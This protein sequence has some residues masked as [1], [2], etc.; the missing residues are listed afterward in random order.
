MFDLSRILPGARPARRDERGASATEY[1]LLI[2][3]IAA[4]IAV[5]V[6][7][8]GGMVLND[9]FTNTCDTVSASTTSGGSC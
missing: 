8:F 1:G 2:S 4:V 3:G 6:Y 5:V 7:T 9:L